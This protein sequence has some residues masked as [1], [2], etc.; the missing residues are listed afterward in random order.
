MRSVCSPNVY[1]LRL[2]ASVN[3][4]LQQAVNQFLGLIGGVDNSLI[5]MAILGFPS[6][7]R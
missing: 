4:W 6:A 2:Q 1:H 7:S 3:W 5:R